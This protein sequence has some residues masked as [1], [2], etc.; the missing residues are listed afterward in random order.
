M[1]HLG[2]DRIVVKIHECMCAVFTVIP[3]AYNTVQHTLSAQ[4]DLD[5]WME[6]R[7]WR[8]EEKGALERGNGMGRMKEEKGSGGKRKEKIE[9]EMKKK[10][11]RVLCL[12][13]ITN[14]L[15]VCF[16]TYKMRGKK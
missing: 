6:E 8:R 9:E 4:P 16:L 13:L 5:G 12:R 3:S 14:Q 11:G 10:E 2:Y 15:C 7:G 1:Y